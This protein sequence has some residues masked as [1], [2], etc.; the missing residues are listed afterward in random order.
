MKNDKGWRKQLELVP[1]I[2]ISII[3]F[4]FIDNAEVFNSGFG[5]V[6]SLFSYFIW[7]FLISY[8]LNPIMVSLDKRTGNRR[9][10]TLIILYTLVLGIIGLLIYIVTPSL[11]RNISQLIDNVPEYYSTTQ[12][13]IGDVINNLRANDTLGIVPYLEGTIGNLTTRVTTL[14]TQIL[15]S[16]LGFVLKGTGVIATFLISLIISVY[17]LKEK[18]NM[19]S[20]CKKLSD[21]LFLDRE[22]TSL[23]AVF[24]SSV[25]DIFSRYII[26][27]SI[28]SAIIGLMCYIGLAIIGIPYAIVIGFLVGLTNMIPYFG[29]F[30]G[31]IPAFI[32][33]VFS[34]FWMAVI[35]VFFI[36]LLQQFDGWYLGPRILGES[37]G[38]SPL[39][40]I[41][42]I[43]VGG[44]LYGLMGMFLGVPV[45]SV[46]KKLLD[47]YVARRTA[48]E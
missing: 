4:K 15:N 8:I 48:I 5:F 43:T 35:T 29:P 33:T 40:I 38:M 6:L 42:A 37:V 41:L 22:R 39:W 28:D 26:G 10:L 32:I 25:D 17:M 47:E 3:L 24:F 31:M 12:K 11:V 46:L 7:A 19:I 9:W 14:F 44:R 13:W 36:F 20:G 21:A 16:I 2:V 27:K 18:E 23:L 45:V 30:I 34:G 1:V